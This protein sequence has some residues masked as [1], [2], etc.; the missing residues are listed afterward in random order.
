MDVPHVR[1]HFNRLNV[2]LTPIAGS[3]FTTKYVD[4]STGIL[5][6]TVPAG[7]TQ[8]L[9]VLAQQLQKYPYLMAGYNLTEPTE[10]WP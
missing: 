8:A 6:N 9:G 4:F 1:N 5:Q 10:I 7:P 2:S 3:P